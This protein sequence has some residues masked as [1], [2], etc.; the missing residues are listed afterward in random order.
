M[1]ARPLVLP[2]PFNGEGRWEEWAYHFESV[3]DVNGWDAAQKLKW[4][5]VRLTGRAQIAFQRLSEE[6]RAD[7]KEAKKALTERFEPKSRKSRY[8]AEFQTRRKKKTEAWADFAED[9]KQLADHA[10]PDLEDK[11]R[12]RLALNVYLQNLEHPQVAFSVRQ[13][14]PET[15]DAAV[16]ATLEIETYLPPKGCGLGVSGVEVA[17][18]TTVAAVNPQEKLVTLVEKLVERVEKLELKDEHLRANAR[19]PSEN[20]RGMLTRRGPTVS[21]PPNPPWREDRK[22]Q[23]RRSPVGLPDLTVCVGDAAREAMWP[24]TADWGDSLRETRNPRR[25]EPSV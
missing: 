13:K 18:E 24:G 4:L 3:A 9:L 14:C 17:D 11:A 5:K 12:E 21:D 7:F 25:E 1:A 10:F 19:Q 16:S 6:T 2:E 8:Q 23:G 15:L 20:D 22:G